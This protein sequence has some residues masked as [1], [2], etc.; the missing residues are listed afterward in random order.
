M[1]S[2]EILKKV[3]HI[4]IYTRHIVN[5]FM[6][7]RYESVFKGRGIEFH[8]VREYAP[9][10]DVRTIDWNVTARAG[11]PY[12]KLFSEERQLTVMLVVDMSSSGNFASVNRFKRELSAEL[13]A[14]MALSAMNNNDQV[15]LILHTDRVEKFI[16]PKKGRHHLLRVIRELLAFEPENKGTDISSALEFLNRVTNRKAIVFMI[17]DFIAA[18]YDK[19]LKITSK[20]HDVVAI[21][22]TDPR[23]RDLPR[24]GMVHLE[25]A[26]TGRRVFVDTSNKKLRESYRRQFDHRRTSLVKSLAT[27]GVD[28]IS[29]NTAKPYI[30]PIIRFFKM[31]ARRR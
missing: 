10:D 27:M 5:D 15:G 19:Q 26:E 14:V 6:A 4:Q 8:E 31:R 28:L 24:V 25:D 21:E 12:I 29:V 7:G 9:G 17:S 13:S 11:R 2:K 20:R 30:Q 3:R 18:G 23:E 1:I 22:I 16:P